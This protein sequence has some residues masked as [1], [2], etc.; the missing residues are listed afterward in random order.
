MIEVTKNG[1]KDWLK[2]RT[3]GLCM[4]F[5]RI[6]NFHVVRSTRPCQYT[7][8]CFI[9]KK[10]YRNLRDPGHVR[11]APDYPDP[12]YY[13]NFT[14]KYFFRHASLRHLRVEQVHFFLGCPPRVFLPSNWKKT[15]L[16]STTAT[17]SRLARRSRERWRT[18]WTV[19]SRRRSI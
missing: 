11:R 16:A 10:E 18:R 9:G 1:L 13:L 8:A 5:N 14:Q 4:V 12:R 2:S 17:A 15:W 6:L 3:V 19:M 7:P